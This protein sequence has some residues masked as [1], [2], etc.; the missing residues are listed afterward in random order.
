M[1]PPRPAPSLMRAPGPRGWMA[2][3]AAA[4]FLL[5]QGVH[6][7]GARLY[8]SGPIQVT[9]DGRWVWVANQD[10]DSVSLTYT[11]AV[12]GSRIRTAKSTRRVAAR[13][14]D[15]EEVPL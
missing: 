9:A 1:Q 15:T 2:L 4:A 6:A 10:H 14:T 3:L 7:A 5:P 12:W 11:V 8:K 13:S